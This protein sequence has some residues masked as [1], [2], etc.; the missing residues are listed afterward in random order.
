MPGHVEKFLYYV[1]HWFSSFSFLE[2]ESVL[3]RIPPW[4][5]ITAKMQT[6][7]AVPGAEVGGYMDLCE[8]CHWKVP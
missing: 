1:V 8:H 4:K 3:R 2:T 5:T 7:A 6:V